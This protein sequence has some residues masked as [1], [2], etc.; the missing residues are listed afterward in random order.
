MITKNEEVNNQYQI[1][2]DIEN[3]ILYQRERLIKHIAKTKGWDEKE[4]LKEFLFD[5]NILIQTGI[6]NDKKK[7]NETYMDNN[8]SI[9]SDNDSINSI[10]L[11]Q[12]DEQKSTSLSNSSS[13]QSL[14]SQ[15]ENGNQNSNTIVKKKRGRPKKT[16]SSEQ[17]K[18][19]VVEKKKRGRPRKKPEVD[20]DKQKL[21]QPK[22]KRGRPKKNVE[23]QI[24]QDPNID[25]EE[26]DPDDEKEID[27]LKKLD[28]QLYQENS[29]QIKEAVENLFYQTSN[30][31]DS[32]IK[33]EINTQ[34]DDSLYLESD[35][36]ESDI[37]YEEITCDKIE[38][39]GNHYLLD[40]C[41]NNIYSLD[42]NNTFVGRFDEKK[43]IID[44]NAIE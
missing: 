42:E 19:T 28:T 4:L 20:K 34:E 36:E 32:N 29:K 38:Y 44:F 9:D 1:S 14:D 31:S 43:M 11:S 24:I 35:D 23:Q 18:S 37:E 13:S 17:K 6:N 39:K 25:L 3:L 5:K 22:R 26:K 21:E 8:N 10:I 27:V 2:K 12:F 7:S 15:I 30:N 40:K 16:T 41:N 33:L